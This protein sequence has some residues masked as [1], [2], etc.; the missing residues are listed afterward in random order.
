[1]PHTVAKVTRSGE[2]AAKTWNQAG[3]DA[4]LDFGQRPIDNGLNE[5]SRYGA[6]RRQVASIQAYDAAAQLYR[7]IHGRAHPYSILNSIALKLVLNENL[8]PSKAIAEVQESMNESIRLA[9][10]TR[11]IWDCAG[12]PDALV[13]LFLLQGNLATHADE[14]TSK[15]QA[16]MYGASKKDKDSIGGQLKFLARRI[17]DA[18]RNRPLWDILEKL[19]IQ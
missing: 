6:R 14:V 17:S 18:N 19:A 13:M 11:D 1:M 8:D 9:K 16:V 5:G 10:E 12:E 7:E 2:P 15:Y 3:L 4:E